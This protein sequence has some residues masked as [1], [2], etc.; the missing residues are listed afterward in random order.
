M[1]TLVDSPIDIMP[2]GAR[3]VRCADPDEV[4]EAHCRALLSGDEP[5]HWIHRD[6]PGVT[7]VEIL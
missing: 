7:W 5:R 3:A 4:M 6:W 2:D 1:P